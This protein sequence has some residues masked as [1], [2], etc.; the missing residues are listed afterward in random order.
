MTKPRPTKGRSEGQWALGYHEPLNATE[1]IKKDDDPLNVR[2]R[3]ENL[4]AVRG[5]D[6]IDKSDLRGRFRWLGLYTQRAEGYDG[7]WTGDENA[8]ELDARYY[9]MRVRTDGKAQSAAAV[10]TLE[11]KSTRLNTSHH[12]LSRMPTSA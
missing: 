1:Q 7:T 6:S 8:D 5:F 4:Y 10:R 9:M 11:P 2:A 12:R 3:I